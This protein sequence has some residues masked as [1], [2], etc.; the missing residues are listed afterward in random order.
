MIVLSVDSAVPPDVL[1]D[2]AEAIG[3]ALARVVDLAGD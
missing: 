1:A 2:I 3:A